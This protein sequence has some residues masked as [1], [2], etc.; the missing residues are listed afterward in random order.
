MAPS[1]NDCC[2]CHLLNHRVDIAA[3]F[4]SWMYCLVTDALGDKLSK[5]WLAGPQL[6][7]NEVLAWRRTLFIWTWRST[8]VFDH[9]QCHIRKDPIGRR[10]R[11]QRE[12]Q[13]HVIGRLGASFK[14]SCVKPILK[15]WKIV[16]NT[17]VDLTAA[18]IPLLSYYTLFFLND[19]YR[20]WLYSRE[21]GIKNS[22]RERYL[23]R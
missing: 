4:G 23:K 20:G 12:T 16:F 10:E 8:C 18:Q 15:T 14:E 2:W 6:L 5:T 11:R 19:G 9:P 7:P 22:R 13:H 21:E 3:I 17:S 1:Q